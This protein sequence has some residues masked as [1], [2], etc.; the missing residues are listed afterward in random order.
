MGTQEEWEHW[1]ELG[2]VSHEN[3]FDGMDMEDMDPMF[4]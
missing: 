3:P 4:I 1:W 2:K